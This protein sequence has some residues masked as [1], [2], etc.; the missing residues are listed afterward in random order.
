[1]IKPC[2]CLFA[3][4]QEN[5]RMIHD[6][7]QAGV[8]NRTQSSALR[9]RRATRRGHVSTTCGRPPRRQRSR[10]SRTRSRRARRSRPSRPR[11]FSR[12][13]QRPRAPR[14]PP[15][16]A[17]VTPLAPAPPRTDCRQAHPQ[18]WRYGMWTE[19]IYIDIDKLLV[20]EL[21]WEWRNGR[22]GSQCEIVNK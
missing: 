13:A 17:C 16:R 5:E 12:W 1:M 21:N 18:L 4:R 10:P 6:V 14:E 9:W 15:Y 2:L 8:L 11:S 22:V 19:R 7:L 3:V 20:R